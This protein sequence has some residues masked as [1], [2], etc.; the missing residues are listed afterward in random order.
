MLVQLNWVFG[1]GV[2]VGGRFFFLPERTIILVVFVNLSLNCIVRNI[3]PI[4][5]T[6]SSQILYRQII[7]CGQPGTQPGTQ[8]HRCLWT[9]VITTAFM[10][11]RGGSETCMQ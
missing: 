11:Q 2:G 1:V 5:N 6:F 10:C 9:A 3:L 7:K 4:E 8:V